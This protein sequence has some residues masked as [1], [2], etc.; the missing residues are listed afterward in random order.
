MIRD[1]TLGEVVGT[2][3]FRSVT[4]ANQ[5]A[6][7]AACSLIAFS[8]AALNNLACNSD[9]A[10]A[11]FVLGAFILAFN[12][13][14]RGQVGYADRRI[15]GVHML[16]TRAGGAKVSMRRSSLRIS[17]FSTSSGSAITATVQ[18]EVWIR[19]WDSVSG[20]RWTRGLQTQT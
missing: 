1:P 18:A 4:A 9:M 8:S 13:H 14:T 17:T 10:R 12:H 6:R 11:R 19:P 5:V 7:S 3:S 15:S 2:D 20:T 16:A